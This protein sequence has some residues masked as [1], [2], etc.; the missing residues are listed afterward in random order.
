MCLGVRAYAHTGKR[1]LLNDCPIAQRS[2]RHR[3][4]IVGRLLLDGII[5]FCLFGLASCI[6][7]PC[8]PVASRHLLCLDY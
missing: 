6:A 2:S 8:Y 7:E 1:L 5:A 3:S 4:Y